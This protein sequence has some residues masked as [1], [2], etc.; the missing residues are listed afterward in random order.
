VT[1]Q[2]REGAPVSVSASIINPH[3]PLNAQTPIDLPA[4]PSP[5]PRFAP[6]SWSPDGK[7][8]AGQNGFTT[9]GISIYSIAGRSFERLSEIGEWPVWLPDSRRIL[10]ISR[11]REFHL[12]DTRTKADRIVFSVKRDTLGSPRLTRNGRAAFF[13]RRVTEADVWL[14]DFGQ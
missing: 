6:N 1:R 13:S 2:N 10:Y 3:L 7:W 12:L 9:Q 8:L 11:G 5:N 14:V 4:A